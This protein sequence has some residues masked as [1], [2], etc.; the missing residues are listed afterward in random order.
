MK[1]RAPGV[2]E[3][4]PLL[5]YKQSLMKKPVFFLIILALITSPRV[6]AE[7]AAAA[8]AAVPPVAAAPQSQLLDQ[9]VAVVNDEV[10]TQSEIDMLLRP[11]YEQYKKQFPETQLME[12]MNDARQKLLSQMIEDKLVFQEAKSQKI[13]IDE[14]EIDQE[15]DLFKKRFK[16]DGEL[17]DALHHEGL[18]MNEMRERIRRQAMIRRLQD[19]EVRAKIVVSPLEVDA[20]YKAHPDEFSSGEKVRVRSITIRK[21]AIAQ[22]KGLKD[23]G[24]KKKIENIRKKILSGESFG[25]LAKENSEDT[26]TENEGL[27]DWLVRGDMIPEIDNAIF[28]LKQGEI[29]QV[30]ESPMGYHLFRA[31]ERKEKF[32]K[33]LEE[34]REEI[35]SIL[36]RQKFEEHFQE[37]M[38]EL[39]RN[40]YIS[41]R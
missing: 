30:I 29:S 24:A 2:L 36:F 26:N 8:S 35:F 37:W 38:K 4:A 20:Y 23:E 10:I 32:R 15:V 14:A 13:E 17:E 28:K 5:C 11:I 31:E 40:A 19:Q 25:K 34:S 12:K 27:G 41:V 1:R 16:T 6:W 18:S 9:V 33:T 39:K 21:D 22:E 3:T 7:D